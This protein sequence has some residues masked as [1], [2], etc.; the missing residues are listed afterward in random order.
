MATGEF[1]GLL[2]HDDELSPVALYEVV[3]LL[4]EHPEADVIYSDEDKLEESGGRSEPFFKPDW[5]LSTCCRSIT[6]AILAYT[7]STG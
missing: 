3:K 7:G 4:Q 2:D 5:S 6:C 1:I